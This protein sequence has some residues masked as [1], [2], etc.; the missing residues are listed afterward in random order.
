MIETPQGNPDVLTGPTFTCI[1]AE[2]FKDLKLGDRFYYENEPS[3]DKGTSKSAF[4]LGM[5]YFL[6]YKIL[7]L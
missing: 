3:E 4:T 1:L 5:K 2:Q 6:F 7:R